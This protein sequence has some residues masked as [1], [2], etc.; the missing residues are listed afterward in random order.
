MSKNLKIFS[1][2][3]S[4]LIFAICPQIANAQAGMQTFSENGISF[5]YPSSCQLSR[6]VPPPVFIGVFLPTNDGSNLT[7]AVENL[8]YQLSIQEYTQK[9]IENL[10]SVFKCTV[11]NQR[12]MNVAGYP[13]MSVTVTFNMAGTQIQ[14]EQIYVVVGMR[15]Y[16]I[17]IT[18]TPNNFMGAKQAAYR[19]I[20]TIR[21]QP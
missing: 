17:G 13:A 5:E 8:P 3:L 1:L 20:N 6:S 15:A 14:Q 12:P 4:V 18:G 7:F 16:C 11:D 9:A 10:N 19:I 21:F 2:V